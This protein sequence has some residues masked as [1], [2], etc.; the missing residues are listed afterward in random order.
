VLFKPEAFE[1]LT[2]TQWDAARARH[3]I[4]RTVADVDATFDVEKLWP[5]DEWDGWQAATPMKNLYVGAA[6]VIHVLDVLRGR[7]IAETQIDLAAAGSAQALEAFRSAPDY[8]AGEK[9]PATPEA[10]LLTGETGIL[11][12]AWSLSPSDDLDEALLACVRQ[13]VDKTVDELMWGSPGTL[14]VARAMLEWTGRGAWSATCSPYST[15]STR[16][17]ASAFWRTPPR[18]SRV[19]PSSKTGSKT[20]RRA[21]ATTSSSTGRSACSGARELRG[22]SPPPPRTST[23]SFSPRERSSPGEPIRPV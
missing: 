12:V 4:R 6:G 16:I 11:V 1:P 14:L 13:N 10:G 20:G 21:S 9:L 8:I 5:A 15:A 3:G 17:G 2:E 22:S 18:F 7:G 23:K 19:L